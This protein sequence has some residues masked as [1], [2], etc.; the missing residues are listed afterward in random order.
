MSSKKFRMRLTE[1]EHKLIAEHRALEQECEEKGIPIDSVN[2]YWY[3]GKH[4]SLHVKNDSVSMDSMREDI[5]KEMNKYSP[6][7][8]KIERT[9]SKDSH[10]LVV[11]PA[12]VHIGKLATAFE[13]GEDYN[14]QVA[15]KRVLEGVKGI[16][17]KTSDLI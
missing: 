12:D 14:S 3:K 13:T 5:I 4:F 8:N 1:D 15:V 10:C 6:K 9:K 16:L 7:Y 17:D 11:D 2:H